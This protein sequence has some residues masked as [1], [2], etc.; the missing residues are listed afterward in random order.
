[1]AFMSEASYIPSILQDPCEESRRRTQ[2]PQGSSPQRKGTEMVVEGSSDIAE[3]GSG[4]TKN[5]KKA[6]LKGRFISCPNQGHK[7]P[8]KWL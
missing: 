8:E 2:W 7:L 5:V 4:A 6:L 3:E 1:M